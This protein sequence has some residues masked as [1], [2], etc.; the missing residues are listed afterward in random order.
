MYD[1]TV[2]LWGGREWLAPH[3]QAPLRALLHTPAGLDLFDKHLQS[4]GESAV[5]LLR[6]WDAMESFAA[7]V[8]CLFYA[9]AMRCSA[10]RLVLTRH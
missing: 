7:Y 9:S 6:C 2:G 1:M 8:W 10:I 4:G 5:A 3:T